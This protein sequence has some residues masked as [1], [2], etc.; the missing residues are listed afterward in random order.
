MPD[1]PRSSPHLRGTCQRGTF[2][3]G[4]LAA[5]TAA[6]LALAACATP[7]IADGEAP[8]LLLGEQ[9]DAPSHQQAHARVVGDLAAHGRLAGL[10]LEM[11]DQEAGTANLPPSATET[12]VRAAL[13]WDEAAW[14]W[15]PYAPAVMAA[16]RAGVPVA[17][18]NLPRAKMRAA[19]ADASLDGLLPAEA[20]ARQREAIRDGHCGLLPESQLGPMA[21]IQIARDR[22]MAQTVTALAQQA[23][24]GRRVVLL[25]GAA[26]VDVELGVPRHLPDALAFRAQ[27]WPAQ[28]PQKDYCQALREG[29]RDGVQQSVPPAAGTGGAPAVASAPAGVNTPSR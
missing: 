25:A 26:H 10:A 18:A 7:L 14:P 2:Q 22:A 17:G 12:E 8:A 27:A 21:R 4:I 29:M 9:H 3:R 11:A 1:L 16:V 23:A 6:V 28:P 5:A 15:A 24:P 20:L 19:M 13:R